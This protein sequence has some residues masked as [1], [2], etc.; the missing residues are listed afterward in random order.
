MFCLFIILLVQLRL[1]SCHLLEIATHSV[2]QVY[3]FSSVYLLSLFISRVGF[4]SRIWYL[5]SKFLFIAFLL[6]SFCLIKV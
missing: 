1:L 6:L 4:K 5:F 2:G 3:S